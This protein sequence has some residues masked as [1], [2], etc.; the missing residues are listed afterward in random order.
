MILSEHQHYRVG[1][2]CHRYLLTTEKQPHLKSQFRTKCFLVDSLLCYFRGSLSVSHCYD[3]LCSLRQSQLPVPRPLTVQLVFMRKHSSPSYLHPSHFQLSAP[4]PSIHISQNHRII[5][6]LRLEMTA[7]NPS[8]ST[9]P[10]FL[11]LLSAHIP[12]LV[13]SIPEAVVPGHLP[14]PQ[15]LHFVLLQGCVCSP[16]LAA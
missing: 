1:R 9:S 12:L 4:N 6:S 10:A 3:W 7:V 2:H 8:I 14:L 16:E 5:E 15:P 11:S 13:H